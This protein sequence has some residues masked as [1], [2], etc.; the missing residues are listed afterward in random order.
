VVQ[1]LDVAQRAYILDDGQFALQGSAE[2][3]RNDPEIK[4]AYL[5]M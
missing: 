3:I 1:S 2:A 4:R 5:G